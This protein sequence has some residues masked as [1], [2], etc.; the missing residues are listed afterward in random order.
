MRSRALGRNQRER[1]LLPR[2]LERKLGRLLTDP[3]FADG[4]GRTLWRQ[5]SEDRFTH[6]LAH[7]QRALDFQAVVLDRVSSPGSWANGGNVVGG[8]KSPRLLLAEE[9][10]P[11]KCQLKSIST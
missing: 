5:A 3:R 4:S 9:R 8:K 7:H 1:P 10:I 2:K 6:F 11:R